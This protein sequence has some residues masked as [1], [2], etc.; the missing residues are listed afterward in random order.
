M[1][2]KLPKHVD[3]DKAKKACKSQIDSLLRDID[4]NDLE[5]ID[6]DDVPDIETNIPLSPEKI[7]KKKKE[8]Y[9]YFHIFPNKELTREEYIEIRKYIYEKLI[10][11]YYNEKISDVIFCDYDDKENLSG[12]KL[13][14]YYKIRVSQILSKLNDSYYPYKRK[15]DK[16]INQYNRIIYKRLKNEK[17]S[18]EYNEIKRLKEQGLSTQKIA[19]K[20]NISRGTVYKRIKEIEGME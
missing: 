5:D 7:E 14:K 11:K 4:L 10:D 2:M 18:Q 12:D 1:K 20:L 15:I 13:K 16:E 3:N 17:T 6:W 9:E 8:E 19:M